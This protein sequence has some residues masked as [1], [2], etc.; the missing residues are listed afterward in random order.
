[1]NSN[2]IDKNN[3]NNQF[4]N[5]YVLITPAKNEEKNLQDLI[6]SIADQTVKPIFWVIVDDGSTDD[7]P[8]IIQKAMEKYDWIQSIRL[9][10]HPRDIGKHYAYVCNEGFDFATKFCGEKNVFYEYIGIVDADMRLEVDF[11]Y[12]L[13]NEFEKNPKLGIASGDEYY[14]ENG[15]LVLEDMRDDLPVGCMRLWKRT[16]FDETGK[17][18]IS[19]FPDSVSNAMA[20]LKGWDT[21]KFN[22]IKA[23]QVRKTRGLDGLWNGYKI[24]GM[25]DYF[26]NYHPLFVFAKGMKYLFKYPYYPGVGYWYGYSISLLLRRDKIDN[27]MIRQYYYNTKY[28]EVKQFFLK[29]KTKSVIK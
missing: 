9:S 20:K 21:R 8:N 13:I 28:Q 15:K 27:E 29:N 1:M 6:Q 3:N 26:R 4:M 12:K 14:Y 10:E 16:C 11:F 19:D 23:I 2:Y 18:C 24:V 5:Q 17:Y 25:A 7:S 22:Y